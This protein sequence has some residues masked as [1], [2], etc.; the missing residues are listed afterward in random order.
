[1]KLKQYLTEIKASKYHVDIRRQSE[2]IEIWIYLGEPNN[3]K[4]AFVA[5]VHFENTTRYLLEMKFNISLN[6]D[7]PKEDKL[8]QYWDISFKDA[9]GK[10]NI[11]P[12]E[13]GIAIRLFA[14][15]EEQI[16]KLIKQHKPDVFRFRVSDHSDSRYKLYKTIANKISKTPYYKLYKSGKQFWFISKALVK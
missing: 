2:V 8:I 12:K 6:I 5:R 1:M 16:S 7:E 14:A 10:E 13:K 11:A 9:M 4:D 15:L 3:L